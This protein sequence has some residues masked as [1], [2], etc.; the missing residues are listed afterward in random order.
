MLP[1]SGGD[2]LKFQDARSLT[3]DCQ[4]SVISFSGS[5]IYLKG[6]LMVQLGENGELS[7]ASAAPTL[8]AI[9]AMKEEKGDDH[10]HS[11]AGLGEY[12]T[13]ARV[14]VSRSTSGMTEYFV[15]VWKNRQTATLAIF[16]RSADGIQ[17]IPAP[18]L[19]SKLPV[20]GVSYLPAP[21]S[22]A[23]TLG[24]TQEVAPGELR[25]INV[26]WTHRDFTR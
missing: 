11:D 12:M 25:L 7:A 21:D 14:D 2:Q 17:S 19:R 23:G 26:W 6:G 13:A 3:G 20:R 16:A 18:L 22:P 5:D 9:P 1:W 15:G 4:A 24:I 10:S 8:P